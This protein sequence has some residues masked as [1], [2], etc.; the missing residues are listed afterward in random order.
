MSLC[1]VFGV[2]PGTGCSLGGRAGIGDGGLGPE[3]LVMLPPPSDVPWLTGCSTVVE[4]PGPVVVVVV[5]V[6][7]DWI[8]S[9]CVVCGCCCHL[10]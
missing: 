1:D 5:V 8:I 10:Q 7:Y 2:S 9:Q 4:P 3:V 6:V